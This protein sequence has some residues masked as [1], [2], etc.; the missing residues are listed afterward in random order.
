[1]SDFLKQFGED[2]KKNVSGFIAVAITEIKSGVSY[3]SLSADKNFDPELAAAF[4]LEVVKA[5]LNAINAL[6]LNQSIDDILI[7]LSSQIH[8]IDVSDNNEYFIY[9]AVDASKANMGMTKAL[10]NKYK[11]EISGNL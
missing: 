1:M 6:G 2:L 5:K 7:N 3:Y 9:L 4:N 8:I 11:K 10:L